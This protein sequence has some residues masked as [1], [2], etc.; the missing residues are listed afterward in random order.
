MLCVFACMLCVSAGVHSLQTILARGLTLSRL[1]ASAVMRTRAAAPSFKVLA[2]AAVTVPT[3]QT[4][5]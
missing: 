2:L 3:R 1:A 4:K 5:P